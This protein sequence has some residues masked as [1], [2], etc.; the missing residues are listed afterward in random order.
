MYSCNLHSLEDQKWSYF[1]KRYSNSLQGEYR[2]E[3]V[4]ETKRKATTNDETNKKQNKASKW[5]T[6]IAIL[7]QIKISSMQGPKPMY[8][9][10]MPEIDDKITL[11]IYTYHARKTSTAHSQNT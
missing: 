11:L 9:W 5:S 8:L 1:Y 3:I 4:Q 2:K 7:K 10:P 6:L